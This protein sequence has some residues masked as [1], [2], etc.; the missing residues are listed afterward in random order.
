MSVHSYWESFKKK[1]WGGGFKKED[2]FRLWRGVTGTNTG[3]DPT[4]H[5]LPPF[6]YKNLLASDSFVS[7][8][9]FKQVTFPSH[10]VPDEQ[11]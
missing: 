4:T 2:G 6:V 10:C 11:A 8:S 9:V 7:F 3:L 1:K 5:C